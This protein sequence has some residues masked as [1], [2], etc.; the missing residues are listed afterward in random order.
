[1]NALRGSTGQGM[2]AKTQM[3]LT[4]GPS[5]PHSDG[6]GTDGEYPG[7]GSRYSADI[8]EREN[9]SNPHNQGPVRAGS[10]VAT[11]PLTVASMG[12]RKTGRVG[13]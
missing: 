5:Y 9:K 12:M 2:A 8:N 1:M 6:P 13:G 11:R 7:V 4:R 3:G 10:H